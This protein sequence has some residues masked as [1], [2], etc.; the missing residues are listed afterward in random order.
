M[1]ADIESRVE[2]QWLCLF[3]VLLHSP[4]LGS[5]NPGSGG[6]GAGDI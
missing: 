2:G 6:L 4:P 3:V 5:S 1:Y